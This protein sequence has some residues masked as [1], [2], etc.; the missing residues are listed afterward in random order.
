MNHALQNFR[1]Y[2]VKM[3]SLRKEKKEDFFTMKLTQKTEKKKDRK[4]R[5]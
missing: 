3:I 2:S 5:N 1:G 4:I